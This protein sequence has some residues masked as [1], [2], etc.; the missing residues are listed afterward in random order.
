MAELDFAAIR[1]QLLRGGVAPKH[2]R[3]TIAELRDHHADLVSEATGR[4][5]TTAQATAEAS[6]RLGDQEA[7]VGEV[8]RHSELRS[9][10]HRWPWAIY[11]LAPLAVLV[12]AIIAALIALFVPVYVHGGASGHPSSPPWLR[13]LAVVTRELAMYGLPLVVA[14]GVCLAAVRR[15]ASLPWPMVGVVLVSLVGGALD[16]EIRWP[17]TSGQ[18]G[19]L[20]V[21]LSLLP[22]FPNAGAMLVRAAA[23]CLLVLAPFLWLRARERVRAPA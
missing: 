1:E 9:W 6:A 8:L 14:V 5:A 13:S 3:R 22:P 17:N 23:S 16:L 20:N 12:A 21:G 7:L 19:A 11:G 10:A 15:R 4:G 2:V 18:P